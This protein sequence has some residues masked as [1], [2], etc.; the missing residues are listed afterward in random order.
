[1]ALVIKDRVQQASS[2]Y[3]TSSFSLNGTVSGFQSFE[4]I[5]NGNQTYYSATDSTGNWEVGLGAYDG[6]VSALSRDLILAS[7][8]NGLTTIFSGTVNV[9]CTYP[10][11]YALL[12]S[13]SAVASTG[14]G[15]VVLNN[16]ASLV[17]PTISSATIIA[18]N[19][20]TPTAAILTNATGL[21]IGGIT[22][23]G[24]PS[25]TTFLRGDSS[26][27]ALTSTAVTSFSAGT[28]GLTPSASTTG[29]VTLAGT[30]GVA[31]G[32]SGLATLTANYI[33]YGNG[34]SAYQSLSTFTFNGTT[35]STPTLSVTSTTSTTPA[36]SFNASNSPVAMGAS[37]SGSYLQT[38]LQNKSGTAGASTNYI[39]SNDLGTDSTYYGEFG[40]NSSVFSASTPADFFSINNGI[41]FSGH[42]GD[43]SIGSGNGF[44]S[45][46]TWGSAGQSAHVINAS[47]AIGLSTNLGTTPALSGT[48]GFGTANQLMQSAGSAAAPTWSSTINGVSIGAT[49]ASTGTF[50]QL[51]VNG[52]NLNTTISPTGTGTVTIAPAS[53]TTLGTAGV[54]TTLAG[55]ISAITSN[56]TVTLSPTGTGTVTINPAG[57]STIN[58]TSIGATTAAAGSFTA[59]GA[60]SRAS[61]SVIAK[62]AGQTSVQSLTLSGSSQAFTVNFAGQTLATNQVYRVRAYGTLA[63]TSS[64]NVRQ[65]QFTPIWGAVS[66]TSLTSSAV[67]ASVSQTTNWQLEF[68]LTASS[69]TAIW[70]T[71]QLISRVSSA[72]A[73]TIDTVTPASVTGLTSASTLTIGVISSGT[74]TADVLNVHSVIMERIV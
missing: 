26:W 39:L 43:I 5:G 51:T 29:A 13:T 61:G 4:V 72:T 62:S 66:L 73:V 24:T 22:A 74:A 15:D 57:A 53:T 48:T 1:M 19:L 34:T 32:G 38:M 3:T 10:A 50:T 6:N 67:L 17:S 9:F 7:S 42:D 18:S 70:T 68:T 14:S 20:G 58:N 44:K 65:V 28:T 54:T 21:P 35:L 64:A 23:S 8:N 45:Y 63:V 71:G 40:M 55:N 33:P 59:L 30:L 11:E 16:S 36:L 46:F 41:Y 56:Q 52:A 2:Y 69:A 37:V 31:N 49:T 25:S 27:A 12:G 47:G 60:T